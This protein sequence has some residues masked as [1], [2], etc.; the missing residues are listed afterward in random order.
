MTIVYSPSYDLHNMKFHVENKKRTDVIMEALRIL[1][2]KIVEPRM[3]SPS[4]ILRVH[5][6]AHMDYVKG[7]A[8]RGGGLP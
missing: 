1:D 5:S 3:A 7:F 8:E 6:Q 4:D 2:L